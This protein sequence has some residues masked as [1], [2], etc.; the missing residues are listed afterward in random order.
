MGH[1]ISANLRMVQVELVLLKDR[2]LA[3]TKK[4][5]GETTEK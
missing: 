5:Y 3:S 2:G 4:S 1:A